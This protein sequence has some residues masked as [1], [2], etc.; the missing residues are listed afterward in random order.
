MKIEYSWIV[1]QR[2]PSIRNQCMFTSNRL[3]SDIK[4]QQQLI[5]L[6][7]GAKDTVPSDSVRNKAICVCKNAFNRNQC[8]A[9]PLDIIV[10]NRVQNRRRTTKNC[11]FLCVETY[12]NACN[13]FRDGAPP[14]GPAG[15]RNFMNSTRTILQRNSKFSINDRTT[16]ARSTS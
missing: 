4:C 5:Q 7:S 1:E 10:D 13:I 9:P 6:I 16:G 2:N 8:A 11:V 3:E 12:R 14:C 15:A